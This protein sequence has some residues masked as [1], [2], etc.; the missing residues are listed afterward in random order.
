MNKPLIGIIAYNE[1]LPRNGRRYDVSYGRNAEAIERAGGLPVLIPPGVSEETLRAIYQRVDAIF[2]TGGG[3]VHPSRY[4]D[5]K[6]PKTNSI[7]TIRD[8]AEITVTQW[9]VD[10]NLPVFGICR[11]VQVM[12]VALGGTL[13]QDIPSSI[14]TE[15]SHSQTVDLP[16]DRHSHDVKI[17]PNSR[18]AEILGTDVVMVNSLHH[19]S[20]DAVPSNA[21]ITAH[22]PDGGVEALELPDKKFV[23]GVQWHPEDMVDDEYM[24]KLFEAFIEA[25]RQS[26]KVTQ[27]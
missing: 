9:A 12:N 13:I 24:P 25:A 18:L 10:D 21:Q 5:E 2:L 11:G 20:V 17:D 27:H 26:I 7:D 22:A 23:L 15:L 14:E 1:V 3:D 8:E 6:H 16:R 19:Q 4:A